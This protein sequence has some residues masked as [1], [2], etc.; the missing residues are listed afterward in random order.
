L[1]PRFSLSLSGALSRRTDEGRLLAIVALIGVLGFLLAAAAA[2]VRQGQNPMPALL[3]A[4]LPPL[5]VAAAFF[6][7]HFLLRLRRVET[8]PLILPVIALL[9]T[10]GLVMIW[11][12]RGLD[13]VLQQLSRGFLPGMLIVILLVLRP[14][15]IE[16]LRRWAVPLSL[17]GLALA[18]ATALFGAPD[19]S[20][21]R[22]ALRIGPLPPI[23]T[24]ELIKVVLILF[25]AW[26]IDR[27]GEEVEGR[28]RPVIGRLR[29]PALYYFLPGVSFVALASLTLVGMSDFGAVLILGCL[30]VGMLYAGFDNGVF[31]PVAA[32]GLGLAALIGVALTFT[33]EVPAVIRYRFLAFFDPWSTAM[34][35]ENGVSTGITIAAG[36]GYQVQQAIYAVVAGGLTGSGLGLGSPGFIPLAASDFIF[37]AVVEEFGGAVGIAVIVLFAILVLRLLRL[38]VLLPRRQIFERLLLTG[39]AIHFFTQVFVMVG[40]TLNLLPLTGIT[41]PFMSQGGMA[42]L[43]NLSE[44]GLALGLAQR[45]KPQTT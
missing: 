30:F 11:R 37:A 13:G 19:E 28:A 16:L 43:V 21:A 14:R 39:I 7:L 34:I 10:I 18:V 27:Q 23:Q 38:A 17:A 29:L 12:L 45:V 32:I 31:L 41:I 35:V 4:L 26:Y 42:L 2:E 20:G 24:S 6:A 25:L 5:A 1:K 33:W 40:G 36:P 15:W 22:L 8:E 9:F 44:V 3:P